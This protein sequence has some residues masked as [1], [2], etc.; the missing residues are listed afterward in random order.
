ME[1]A[2]NSF[3][4]DEKRDLLESVSL[5]VQ[6]KGAQFKATWQ[7]P[8]GESLEDGVVAFQTCSGKDWALI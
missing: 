6:A 4:F 1:D 5:Q 8:A 3:G 2:L 7:I